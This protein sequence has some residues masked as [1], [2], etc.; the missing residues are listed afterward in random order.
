M[1]RKNHYDNEPKPIAAPRTL[2]EVLAAAQPSVRRSTEVLIPREADKA[3]L[4]RVVGDIHVATPDDDVRMAIGR[5]FERVRDRNGLLPSQ[6]TVDNWIA[7]ALEIH[8]DS[9]RDFM[10]IARGDF[11]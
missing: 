10:K 7:A 6:G 9:Q 1:P 8:H 2:A 3:Q 11:S 5:L 4:R